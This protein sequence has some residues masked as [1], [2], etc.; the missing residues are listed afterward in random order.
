M[1][2]RSGGGSQL[3]EVLVGLFWQLTPAPPKPQ[4]YFLKAYLMIRVF[5]TI[6]WFSRP[7]FLGAVVGL[8]FIVGCRTETTTPDRSPQAT[9]SGEQNVATDQVVSLQIDR[10]D[11]QPIWEQPSN[12]REGITVFELLQEQA[13]SHAE[14]TMQFKGQGE[15]AF[16]EAIFGIENELAGG[17]NWIYYVN[18]QRGDV[19]SGAKILQPD[20]RVLWKYQKYN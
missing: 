8:C 7:L 16:V 18:D 10:Q 2:E 14:L 1:R 3:R 15:T 11:G 13:D 19:S 9:K 6:P 4:I 20:D 12:W 5:R 17:R